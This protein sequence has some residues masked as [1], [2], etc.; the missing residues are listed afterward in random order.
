M[1]GGTTQGLEQITQRFQ[2]DFTAFPNLGLDEH[3]LLIQ[4]G[5]R[6]AKPA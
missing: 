4:V 2:S 6:K 1:A 3:E 5:T